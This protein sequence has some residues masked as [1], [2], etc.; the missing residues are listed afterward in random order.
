MDSSKPLHRSSFY[1]SS[2]MVLTKNGPELRGSD[3]GIWRRIRELPFDS[4]FEDVEHERA[5]IS[6]LG[7]ELPA[8]LTVGH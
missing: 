8:S 7:L 2:K 1:R 6:S 5:L 4:Q 3:N